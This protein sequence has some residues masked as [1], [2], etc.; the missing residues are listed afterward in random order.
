VLAAFKAQSHSSP[1]ALPAG[2]QLIASY[3]DRDPR[4]SEGATLRADGYRFERGLLTG[5][6]PV[7]QGSR[8]MAPCTWSPD[9]GEIYGIFNCSDHRPV[10]AGL[11]YRG[12]SDL[13]TPAGN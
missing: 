6:Q 3:P 10:S 2:G 4:A 11:R 8:R 13:K 5:V 1:H 7:V 9:L 12:L